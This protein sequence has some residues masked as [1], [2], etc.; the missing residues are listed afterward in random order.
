FQASHR[1]ITLS[2]DPS[3]EPFLA[4]CLARDD[5]G[6]VTFAY[7]WRKPLATS[8]GRLRDLIH[9]TYEDNGGEPV[10][11][12]AHSMGGLMIR[13]TLME[14][15]DELWPKIGK[16]VFIGTPHYGAPAIAGYLKNHLWGFD[17][18]AVLGMY[19]GRETL[20]SMWGVLSLLPAPRGIYPGTRP[21]DP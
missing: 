11:L 14:H 8:A 10:H 17:L 15:G 3:Y 21:K 7:D 2:T 20:R 6:H 13:A 1:I 18:M 9:R 4:A 16:I 19:L 12:V 5:F